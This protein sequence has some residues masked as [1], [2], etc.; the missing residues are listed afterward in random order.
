MQNDNLL[1]V[2]G[3]ITPQNVCPKSWNLGMLTVCDKEG[4]F[5]EMILLRIWREI[6]LNYLDRLPV[7]SLVPLQTRIF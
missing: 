4:K 3:K 1:L 6:T 5:A 7:L 2:R